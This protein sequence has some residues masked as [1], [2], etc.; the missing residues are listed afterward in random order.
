MRDINGK[1][2][3]PN[4]WFCEVG[5]KVVIVNFIVEARNLESRVRIFCHLGLIHKSFLA[6]G[7]YPESL[8]MIEEHPDKPPA[9]YEEHS[10][11]D[12]GRFGVL[13]HVCID[14]QPSEALPPFVEDSQRCLVV[15]PLDILYIQKQ[16]DYKL[17]L[18]KGRKLDRGIWVKLFPP[19]SK[20]VNEVKESKR[21][22]ISPLKPSV[23]SSSS[24]QM[25]ERSSV[26]TRPV[27]FLQPM[28]FQRKQSRAVELFF[29]DSRRA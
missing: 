25:P 16:T 18:Y 26:P 29:H 12:V 28:R 5:R 11:S 21:I 13:S 14:R 23:C 2:S 7:I 20:Y 24:D 22:V 8:F 15:Q 19:R 3:C 27:A 4:V 6:E 9:D 1:Q 17:Q 10:R